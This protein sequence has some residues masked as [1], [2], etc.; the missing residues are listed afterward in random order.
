[1]TE[2]TIIYDGVRSTM[3]GIM[4][5]GVRNMMEGRG[6]AAVATNMLQLVCFA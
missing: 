2:K 1:M 6:A 5:A 4:Y 3:G